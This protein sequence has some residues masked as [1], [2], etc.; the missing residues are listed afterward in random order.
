MNFLVNLIFF[1]I[2]FWLIKRSWFCLIRFFIHHYWRIINWLLM[3][4]LGYFPLFTWVF[5]RFIWLN[6]LLAYFLWCFWCFYFFLQ[7]WFL[8]W[9]SLYFL[10]NIL[11]LFQLKSFLVFLL[12]KFLLNIL[13]NSFK[14][15][16]FIGLVDNFLYFRNCGKSVD[17][18][19][20]FLFELI[21]LLFSQ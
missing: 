20:N 9:F 4:K 1:H 2:D 7:W 18:F 21:K 19:H 6:L 3:T 16:R 5:E 17:I 15:R 10:I 8:S 14:F 12:V 13:I 11:R